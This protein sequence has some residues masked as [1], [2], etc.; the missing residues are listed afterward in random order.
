MRIS[1]TFSAMLALLA[2][3]VSSVADAGTLPDYTTEAEKVNLRECDASTTH[4]TF[5]RATTYYVTEAITKSGD[6]F[7]MF[8]STRG[9]VHFW[10]KAVGSEGLIELSRE[11]W[12][13]RMEQ[14][15]LNYF[16]H[17]RGLPESDCYLAEEYF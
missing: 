13:E 16:R 15:S 14:A 12:Y 2:A 7:I 6:A 4:V 9:D 5:Y 3:T 1:K 10:V 11:K 17:V 8:Y